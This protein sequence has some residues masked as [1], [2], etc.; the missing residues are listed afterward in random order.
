MEFLDDSVKKYF[1]TL[2]SKEIEQ[3]KTG[4]F[5]L[6]HP[7]N[8]FSIKDKKVFLDKNY[9]FKNNNIYVNKHNR[10]ADYPL[11]R[12]EF[13]VFNYMLNGECRQIINGQEL[14]MKK[15]DLIILDPNCCHSIYALSEKDILI[16]IILAK[17]S[18]ELRWL[19]DL[20]LKNSTIFNFLM[21]KFSTKISG[22]YITFD[23]SSNTSIKFYLSQIINKYYSDSHFSN[24]ILKCLIPVLI[25]EL[26]ENTPYQ[27]SREL[28]I[29][30]ESHI[31]AAT[32]KLIS[33]NLCD[34]NLTKLSEHLHYNKNYLSNVIKKKTGKTF[35]EHLNNERMEQALT[36]I[37]TTN[38]PIREISVQV[39]INNKTHFYRLFKEK[40]G[41][42][43]SEYRKIKL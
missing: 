12:H 24:D 20:S 37:Q 1:L 5:I 8:I 28:K 15:G 41:T 19:T 4:E 31:V 10:F 36:L 18:I 21:K 14:F 34:I 38:L 6:D 25:M 39:G 3:K 23:T 40:Y 33:E 26:I 22:N 27:L 13:F 32:Q 35:T 16:N 2:N 43:P 9:F 42:L 17:E 30:S 11:H 7:K 29:R